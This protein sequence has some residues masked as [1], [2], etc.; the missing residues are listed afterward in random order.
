[1]EFLNFESIAS[2]ALKLYN[3]VDLKILYKFM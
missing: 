2:I 3:F 1:M